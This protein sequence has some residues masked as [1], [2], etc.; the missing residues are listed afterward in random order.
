[1][2]LIN[3]N[4]LVAL[5]KHA[6][7]TYPEECC[8]FIYQNGTVHTGENIQDELNRAEPERYNR[9]TV[10]GYTFSVGD[11]ILLND[12]FRTNNPVAVI[13][14]SHPDV[15][16]YFSDE[17]IDKALYDG[18]PIYPVDYLVIDVNSNGANLAKI[19]T[20][21]NSEFVCRDTHDLTSISLNN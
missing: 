12:S 16:A 8:G 18:K 6:I 4:I 14:H 3:D 7:S 11:T 21:E 5:T 15:G 2:L 20:W 19:F 1:M 10:R 13:Y 9:S 17:D